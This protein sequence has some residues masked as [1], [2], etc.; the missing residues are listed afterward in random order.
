MIWLLPG[1]AIGVCIGVS[2]SY[3][4]LQR[5]WMDQFTTKLAI[6]GLISR[7]VQ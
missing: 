1:M 4:F 2:V 3:H 5:R 6:Q 7:D